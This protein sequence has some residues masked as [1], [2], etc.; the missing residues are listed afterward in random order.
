VGDLL[1]RALPVDTLVV[2]VDPGKALN[3][4]WLSTDVDGLLLDPLTLPVLR[5]G[6]D[7]LTRL[8]QLHRG[9]RDP[10]IAIETTGALHQAWAAELGQ[11]FPDSVR[12]F[13]PSEAVAARSQLGSRRFKTDDRDCAALTYL[14]RQGHGRRLGADE[15]ELLTA[16][17]FRRGLL[18]ER[19]AAQQRLHDQV[20]ALCP[21]LSAPSGH[22]LQV[23]VA[24]ARHAC[25][26]IYRMLTTQDAF[27]E[28]RYRRARHQTGR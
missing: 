28:Q 8:I 6:I 18:A 19:K 2:A 10:V 15:H 5:S 3:R 4:I 24:I 25:R 22:G 21:G 20:N 17:R 11:R 23:R 13:A 14:A 1:Q 16:V 27:D 7:E 26:L 9:A 12:L